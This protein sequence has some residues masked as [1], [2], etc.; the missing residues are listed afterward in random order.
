VEH[1]ERFGDLSSEVL[2]RRK[3]LLPDPKALRPAYF[4][5]WR[6]T[7]SASHHTPFALANPEVSQMSVKLQ[8]PADELG[9]VWL[10]M[11]VKGRKTYGSC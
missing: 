7:R 6:K 1:I 9:F 2:W 5:S 3:L 11:A 8:A 4:G 10:I